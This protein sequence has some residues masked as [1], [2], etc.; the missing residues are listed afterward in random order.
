MVVPH[1]LARVSPRETYELLEQAFPG[2]FTQYQ[3]RQ[4]QRLIH[5]VHDHQPIIYGDLARKLS[6]HGLL[7]S[8]NRVDRIATEFY[9]FNVFPSIRDLWHSEIT[10]AMNINLND[11]NS[12]LDIGAE[13]GMDDPDYMANERPAANN[14]NLPPP[15]PNLR[16]HV[17]VQEHMNSGFG[18]HPTPP[19]TA[20]RNKRVNS[21][22]RVSRSD[23]R[24]ETS[25]TTNRLFDRRNRTRSSPRI[26]P[27]RT[28]IPNVIPTHYDESRGPSTTRQ[29][30]GNDRDDLDDFD[31]LRASTG[32]MPR[33]RGVRTHFSHPHNATDSRFNTVGSSFY[34]GSMNVGE[35]QETLHIPLI[36]PGNEQTQSA[37]P[38]DQYN[39]ADWQ[40]M[41][42]RNRSPAPEP[43][44]RR[45]QNEE[46]GSGSRSRA[47]NEPEYNQS[48]EYRS[49]VPR[50][51]QPEGTSRYRERNSYRSY[52]DRSRS[53]WNTYRN[54]SNDQRQYAR[55]FQRDTIPDDRQ[56]QYYNQRS[57]PPM[58][59][60]YSRRDQ[61]QYDY[62]NQR[63]RSPTYRRSRQPSPEPTRRDNAIPSRLHDAPT[64]R[65]YNRNEVHFPRSSSREPGMSNRSQTNSRLPPTSEPTASANQTR[66]D[67]PPSTS[68]S[69]SS[70][71]GSTSSSS[72]SE[73]SRSRR[74][75]KKKQKKSRKTHS[76]RGN[77]KRRKNR[78]HSTSTSS[79]T[80]S[81]A[82]SKISRLIPKMRQYDGKTDWQSF[83]YQYTVL[84]KR[85]RWNTREKKVNLFNFLTDRAL[86]YAIWHDHCSYKTLMKKLEARYDN[87]LD[88][89]TAQ[90]QYHELKQGDNE[91]LGDF[92]D[93]V[94]EKARE[95][96]P[97]TRTSE[98]Q[99]SMVNTYLKGLRDL[100]AAWQ[101]K[102][103]RKP[104]KIHE[105]YTYAKDYIASRA[106]FTSGRERLGRNRNIEEV[107]V[108]VNKMMG[109]DSEAAEN[110]PPR[111]KCWTCGDTGHYSPNCPKKKSL[112]P[113]RPVNSPKQLKCSNCSSTD[114]T[115]KDCPVPTKC[116]GCQQTGHLRRQC[117]NMP[118]VRC[119]MTGHSVDT[120]INAVRCSSCFELGH[121]QKNCTTICS[122][123][124]LNGHK[125]QECKRILSS[126]SDKVGKSSPT[127]GDRNTSQDTSQA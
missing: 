76:T 107:R 71:S 92:Y 16:R 126:S 112:S 22:P 33:T 104:R 105:A 66:H 35:A 83:K 61:T 53:Q 111:G 110:S 5:A 36:D 25:P 103:N 42:P 73:S 58:N 100:N 48:H 102:E 38:L 46:L 94:I 59:E 89:D 32:Q 84:C 30:P 106:S 40:Q 45:N 3:K 13:G 95:A 28:D 90:A 72:S 57:R 23:H 43:E 8:H 88:A 85:E 60:H 74:R 86:T 117:P 24:H 65:P 56:N 118:C 26:S 75:R 87:K 15:H 1:W 29:N 121:I 14:Y 11:R 116:E 109:S 55:D 82:P 31:P 78:H 81:D 64:Y 108:R 98:L 9:S 113:A 41:S 52:D 120:C 80:D 47:Q 77:S 67:N 4:I 20:D 122:K 96:F 115:T 49:H 93:R 79:C 63:N 6:T 10:D 17:L 50:N 127:S 39:S 119:L 124:G 54:A 37:V 62:S 19:P 68:T 123:C 18:G 12:T 2:R 99:T 114:H 70:S 51:D 101:I 27:L 21:P 7:D 34:E 125:A 69:S 44:T 91:S 97:E